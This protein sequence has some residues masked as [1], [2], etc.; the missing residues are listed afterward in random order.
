MD[1]R[2]SVPM[3]INLLTDPNQQLIK[4]WLAQLA[5]LG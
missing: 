1:R 3:Q 5:L 4:P 2:E